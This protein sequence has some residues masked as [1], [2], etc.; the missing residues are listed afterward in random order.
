MKRKTTLQLAAAL[1][2]AAPRLPLAAQTLGHVRIGNPGQEGNAGSYYAQDQGYFRRAGVDAELTTLRGSGTGVVA[3]VVGG[4]IEVGEADVVSLATARLR[5]IKVSLIAPSAVWSSALPTAGLLIP[6]G[7]SVRSGRDLE[8][9]AIGVPSLG[10]LNRVTTTVWI[11]KTGGD[12]TKV[13]F[14][15]IPQ[16]EASAALGRGAVDGIVVTEPTL[17]RAIADGHTLVGTMYDAIGNG[18]IET[19]WFATDDWIA[20]N[21]DLATRVG[22]AIREG[23][24]WANANRVQAAAIYRR[25]S[26]AT[27]ERI[28]A[29]YGDVLEPALMQP[30]LDAAAKYH[31]LAQPVNAKELI[32]AAAA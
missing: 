15:E 22:R 29:T 14:V 23:Q 2:A 18:F 28:K 7:G 1:V 10:G 13:K 9:K 24:R 12:A 6:K 8:G 31:T 30:L 16:A 4:S 19:G 11:E 25:Y 21:T 26:G 20:R 5:G 17:S 27:T 3:A 32:S